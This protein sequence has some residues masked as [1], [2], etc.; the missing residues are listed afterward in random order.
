MNCEA[1]RES[2]FAE[3]DGALAPQ[4]AAEL[5]RHLAECAACRAHV[6]AAR[7]LEFAL[8]A[9]DAPQLDDAELAAAVRDVVR[10]TTRRRL[11]PRVAWSAALVAATVLA[12]VWF[13]RNALDTRD[14]S[15]ARPIAETE[16]PRD[17]TQ[18][19]DSERVPE[20]PGAS[21][22][23]PTHTPERTRAGVDVAVATALFGVDA[24]LALE[25]ARLRGALQ[26]SALPPRATRAEVERFALELDAGGEFVR[27]GTDAGLRQVEACLR[28]ASPELA[29]R[30][31]RYLGVRADRRSLAPL[32]R[33]NAP[34]DELALTFLDLAARVPEALARALDEPAERD[35]VLS[36]AADASL[37]PRAWADAL[38]AVGETS[39]TRW[40]GVLE[41]LQPEEFAAC[42]ARDVDPEVLGDVLTDPANAALATREDVGGALASAMFGAT[43]ERAE[44]WLGFCERVPVPEAADWLVDALGERRSRAAALVAL[45]RLDGAAGFAELLAEVGRGRAKRAD[46]VAVLRERADRDAAALRTFTDTVLARSDDAAELWLDALIESEAVGA[47]SALV[48]FAVHRGLPHELRSSAFDALCERAS[49][50]ASAELAGRLPTFTRRERRL[51]ALGLLAVARHGVEA[52]LELA[53]AGFDGGQ[54]ATIRALVARG[55]PRSSQVVQLARLLEARLPEQ[56]VQR[57]DLR[58]TP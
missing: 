1:A 4:D 40:I 13:V 28:D 15:D 46:L 12:F 48:A 19:R 31:A 36:R 56:S 43:G 54:R 18:P 2:G 57:L 39:A 47:S 23:A 25:R 41:R 17:G 14:T 27:A 5:A 26:A 11:S 6:L 30:A 51:A 24:E 52:D 16:T 3:L 53:L 35:L 37:A 58:F 9:A 29:A 49:A 32:S 34:R 44:R 7:R 10:R 8:R 50:A 22:D 55:T 21:V 33:S 42:V 38:V 20:A 45:A